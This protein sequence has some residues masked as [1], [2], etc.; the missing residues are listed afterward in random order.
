LVFPS[1]SARKC[2]ITGDLLSAGA[3]TEAPG[4]HA[5]YVSQPGTVADLI[6]QAARSLRA[7]TSVS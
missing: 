4:S 2:E 7:A 5:I 1:R 3:A 6:T